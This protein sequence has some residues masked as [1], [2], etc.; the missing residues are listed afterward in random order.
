MYITDVLIINIKYN[1]NRPQSYVAVVSHAALL[2]YIMEECC[3]QL[4][5]DVIIW[6]NE[7]YKN[8]I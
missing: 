7:K 6:I 2:G 8:K 5:G 4:R 3:E 1:N